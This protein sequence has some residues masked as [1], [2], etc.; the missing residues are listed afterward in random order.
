MHAYVCDQAETEP[1]VSTAYPSYL[2]RVE[3][4]GLKR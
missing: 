3:A 1:I 4:Q 2:T